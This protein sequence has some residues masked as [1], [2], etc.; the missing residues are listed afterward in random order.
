[1]SFDTC[2]LDSNII[3]DTKKE[4]KFGVSN[5]ASLHVDVHRPQ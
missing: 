4:I 2:E 5:L 3:R 1:M